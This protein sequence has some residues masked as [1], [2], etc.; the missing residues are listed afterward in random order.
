MQRA[1]SLRNP[2]RQVPLQDPLQHSAL[3]A[4]D[5]PVLLHWHWLPVQKP[6]RQVVLVW[7]V[8]PSG[9]CRCVT[10]TGHDGAP[11]RPSAQHT[12]EQQLAPLKQLAC[13]KPHRHVVPL[14]RPLQQTALPEQFWKEQELPLTS[15]H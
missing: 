14:Q 12:P 15:T 10:G 4:Q 9:N 3:L 11:Q 1:P 6:P 5:T 13:S 2:A 7:Q 8:Y